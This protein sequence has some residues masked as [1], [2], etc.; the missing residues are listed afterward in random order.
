MIH[1]LSDVQSTQIGEGTKVWQYSIILAGAVIGKRC[2]INCHTFIEN[3]VIIGDDVTIKSGVY[4]WDG[5]TI[6]DEAFIGPNAT[7]VNDA[8]PKSKRYPS[9]FQKILIKKGVSIGANATLLGGLTIGEY[10]MVAAGSVVT[11]DVEP[12]AL[13][14]GNPARKVGWVNQFGEKLSLVDGQWI[15]NRGNRFFE[16]ESGL[17]QL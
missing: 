16:T 10:S 17:K 12:Y 14:L 1:S 4:L 7:F 9:S 3:D 15:D 11:R 2:N 13:V 8:F 6:E 5:V